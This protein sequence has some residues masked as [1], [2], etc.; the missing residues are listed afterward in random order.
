MSGEAE[1]GGTV[2]LW[3]LP[4]E[5]THE[6]M[7]AVL[8]GYL[9]HEAGRLTFDRGKWGKPHIA[10]QHG[11]SLQF[12]L[13]HT[14]RAAVLAV[15][16]GRATGIDVEV[17]RPWRDTIRLAA[18]FFPAAEAAMLAKA[19]EEAREPLF[20]RLWTRKEAVV[21]AAGDRIFRGMGLPVASEADTFVLT[22]PTERLPGAWRVYDL[23]A[24]PGHVASLALGGAATCRLVWRNTVADVPHAPIAGQPDHASH[25]G[26]KPGCQRTR[27]DGSH[28]LSVER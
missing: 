10:A 8:L 23:P 15:T 27:A 28:P 4:P 9:P 12:S 7:R 2:H 5:D 14:P 25:S 21:K 22:D 19:A 16:A 26:D 3:N 13:S 20:L 17:A 1:L 18:R 11:S 6:A 24:P